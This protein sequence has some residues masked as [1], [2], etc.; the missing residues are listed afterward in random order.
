MIE[1]TLFQPEHDMWRE[2]V[3]RFIEKEIVP[4][5][6]QWEKDGIVPRELWL[7]RL[8]YRSWHRGCKETDLVLGT[9][10]ERQIEALGDADLQL[11]EAL[12]DED[13][14]DIW[15]WLTEKTP[16]PKAEYEPLLATLRL[17]TVV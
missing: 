11:F 6:A 17:Q 10:C 3:R 1:R 14:A 15:N 4:F 16:C 7:K 5:H 2:T 13:D 9:Y 8:T 12:L